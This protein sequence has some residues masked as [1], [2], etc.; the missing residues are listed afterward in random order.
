MLPFFLSQTSKSFFYFIGLDTQLL[1]L[2]I[3][4]IISFLF[5]MP[6]ISTFVFIN[7]SS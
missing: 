7:F 3:L 2:S 6:F 1:D 5:P 4:S